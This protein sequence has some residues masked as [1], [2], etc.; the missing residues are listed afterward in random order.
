MAIQLPAGLIPAAQQIMGF[1]DEEFDQLV[2]ALPTLAG[3]RNVSTFADEVSQATVMGRPVAVQ[4]AEMVRGLRVV[5]DNSGRPA[6]E[7][8][9]EVLQTEE[10]VD[11]DE[12]KVERSVQ[13]LRT[14]VDHPSVAIFVAAHDLIF[15][16][17][18][19]FSG[20]QVVLDTTPVVG[21]DDIAAMIVLHSLRIDYDEGGER[22]RLHVTLDREDLMSLASDALEAAHRE[23]KTV[24]LLEAAGY[25]VMSHSNG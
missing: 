16:R 4:A 18:R 2:E 13:R 22:R 8:I 12:L 9:T 20:A 14:L 1:T 11:F 5:I 23:A 6:D 10:L 24:D 21:A 17:E 25:Q 3:K 19:I 7:V 15:A